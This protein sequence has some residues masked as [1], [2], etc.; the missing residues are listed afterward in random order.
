MAGNEKKEAMQRLKIVAENRD[1]F[2]IA[3]ED[4]KLRGQGDF[5]GTRQ[6]GDNVFYLADIFGDADILK[7]ANEEAK[8]ITSD[9]V[10]MLCKNDDKMKHQIEKYMGYVAI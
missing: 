7:A 3:Q 5:F 10:M 8:R 9:D 4:L 6:S 2:L 1:G